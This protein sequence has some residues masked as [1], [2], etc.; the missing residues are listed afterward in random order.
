MVCPSCAEWVIGDWVLLHDRRVNE[1]V[2]EP[3]WCPAC[4]NL[5]P[6]PEEGDLDASMGS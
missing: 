5:L 6:S 2:R 3:A 4:R 1:V